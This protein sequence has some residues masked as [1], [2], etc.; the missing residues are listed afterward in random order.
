MLRRRMGIPGLLAA[1]TAAISGQGIRLTPQDSRVTAGGGQR[2]ARAVSLLGMDDGSAAVPKL[3]VF[4]QEWQRRM[5][6]EEYLETAGLIPDPPRPDRLAVVAGVFSRV[7]SEDRPFREVV[8]STWMARP[9][10]CTLKQR[11]GPEEG[12]LM[13]VTFVVGK[14]GTVPDDEDV[15]VL[16]IR[17]NMDC[18]KSPAW[19]RYASTTYRW[20]THIIKMDMDAFPYVPTLVA[21]IRDFPTGC[22]NLYGGAAS[23]VLG[24]Q[25]G[26]PQT[27]NWRRL[28][29]MRHEGV[30]V[31]HAGWPLLAE[32]GARQERLQAWRLVA[33]GEQEVPFGGR[34][35]RPGH[36]QVR[37]GERDMRGRPPD[38][39]GEG[40]LAPRVSQTWP[41]ARFL[42]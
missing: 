4:R 28:P 23:P 19:F 15:T 7:G 27:S 20:A 42:S 12:C 34:D 18:G 17:E 3:G 32:R 35:C 9:Y 38:Q 22:Q 33:G 6:S 24:A 30:L 14:N 39:G 41:L 1:L 13:Y 40:V 10:I 16:P 31:L 21:A 2:G 36:P 25:S 8:R 26:P 29:E 5:A 37:D 11:S